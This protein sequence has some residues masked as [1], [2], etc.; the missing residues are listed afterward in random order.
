ME[1]GVPYT[2]EHILKLVK[3]VLIHRKQSLVSNQS[4]DFTDFLK[5][6]FVLQIMLQC[7]LLNQIVYCSTKVKGATIEG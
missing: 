6:G 2:P 7:V 4:Y 3:L 1:D 5:G